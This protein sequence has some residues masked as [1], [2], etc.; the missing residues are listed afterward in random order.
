MKR[1]VVAKRTRINLGLE[2]DAEL[3]PA[4]Q[5]LSS[6]IKVRQPHVAP[7]TSHAAR[8]TSHAARC[9]FTSTHPA[10]RLCGGDLDE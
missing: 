2:N 8:C 4:Y 7:C 10:G 5:L 9:T 3:A 6:A 1:Y